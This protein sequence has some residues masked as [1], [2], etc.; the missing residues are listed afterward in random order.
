MS[1]T[2]SKNGLITLEAI[3][4]LKKID[5]EKM[6]D[7][8]KQKLLS[9]FEKELN[10]H[11]R[12]TIDMKDA[13]EKEKKQYRMVSSANFDL[14]LVEKF[15]KIHQLVITSFEFYLKNLISNYKSA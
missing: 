11:L 12:S 6:D 3:A 9:V 1:T 5:L 15:P 10:E 13:T 8:S 4:H 7:A 14:K 2:H